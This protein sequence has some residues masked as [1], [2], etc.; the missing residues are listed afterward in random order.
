M[1]GGE[2][3]APSVGGGSIP[4][5][6]AVGPPVCRMRGDNPHM[7]QRISGPAAEPLTLAEAKDFLRLTDPS[8]D[9]LVGALLSAARRT[10][11]SATGRVLMTQSWRLVRDA[12]PASGLF[13]LPIAPV[14]SLDAARVRRA[15]GTWEEVHAGRLSLL[16]DRTPQLIGLDRAHL[17]Q[18]AVDHGG[19]VLDVTAGYGPAP[20]DV[21]PDLLQAVRLT[22][23]HF[24]EHRDVVGEAIGLP[25]TVLALIAPYRMLRL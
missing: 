16:G 12:W 22:L 13:L 24:H 1:Y 5:L 7:T 11:E 20:A 6:G 18:P 9:A 19:I 25:G 4:H 8:T 23:A 17:P 14:A 15:D 3:F 2:I 10:I 21:P